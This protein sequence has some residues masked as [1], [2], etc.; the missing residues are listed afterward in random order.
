MVAAGGDVMN[1]GSTAIGLYYGAQPGSAGLAVL[2]F[3]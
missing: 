1:G 3:D 2:I